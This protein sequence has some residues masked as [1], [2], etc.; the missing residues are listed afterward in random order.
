MK[1]LVTSIAFLT[2]FGCASTDYSKLATGEASISN[3]KVSEIHNLNAGQHTLDLSFNYQIAKYHNQPDLY[4]CSVQFLALDGTSFS[5][6]SGRELPCSLNKAAGEISLVLPTILDK[7]TFASK[8]QL[9]SL[10][11]PIEYFLAIHQRTGKHTNR[12]IGK[13]P[14]QVSEI[15]L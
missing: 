7:T 15:K 14:V 5:V 13:T 1:K 9:A 11:Y 2:L 6:S 4:N 12:I 3:F 10:K 8:E